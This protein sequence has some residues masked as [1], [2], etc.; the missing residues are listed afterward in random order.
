MPRKYKYS[1]L[2]VYLGLEKD[3]TGLLDGSVYNAVF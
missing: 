1:S 3:S 2:K